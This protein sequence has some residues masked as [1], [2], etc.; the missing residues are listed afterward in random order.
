ML[1]MLHFY[2]VSLISLPL[3]FCHLNFS[4]QE[5]FPMPDKRFWL[6]PTS[7]LGAHPTLGQIPDFECTVGIFFFF[8]TIS[9]APREG[10]E[11]AAALR[12]CLVQGCSW[13]P[14]APKI[15]GKGMGA[16][17]QLCSQPQ[18]PAA[19]CE[20][21]GAVRKGQHRHYVPMD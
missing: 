2:I 21:G 5:H 11:A 3:A 9:W 10:E 14:G 16:A 20:G 19:A 12:G 18:G 4:R 1:K 13:E 7:A 15:P 8:S 17:A 6:H